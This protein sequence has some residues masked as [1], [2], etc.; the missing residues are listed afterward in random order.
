M[1]RVCEVSV[2]TNCQSHMSA[3]CRKQ[4]LIPSGERLCLVMLYLAGYSLL[5]GIGADMLHDD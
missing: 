2:I 3:Q 4:R 1:S 5:I